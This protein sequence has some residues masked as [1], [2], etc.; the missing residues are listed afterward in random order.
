MMWYQEDL[1][2]EGGDLRGG[3]ES[4]EVPFQRQLAALDSPRECCRLLDVD[5]EP[6]FAALSLIR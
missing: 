1:K 3:L 6:L 2:M 4:G 5:D